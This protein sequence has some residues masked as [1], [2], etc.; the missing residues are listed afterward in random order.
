[1]HEMS[2][3]TRFV[4][5]A[6]KTAEE[7]KAKKVEKVIIEV[8][9]M[10]GLEDYYLDKYY[11]LAVKDTVLDGSILEIDHIPVK[12][13]C[14]MCG[15]IYHPCK[16]NNYLCKCGAGSGKIIEGRGLTVRQVIMDV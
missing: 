5:L 10:A 6:L 15:N 9:D 16:E 2:Y 4:G 11:K 14:D 3:V 13:E 12:A 8:G 1:M 7:K